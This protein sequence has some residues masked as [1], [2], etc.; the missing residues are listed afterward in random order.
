MKGENAIEDLK[1][2]GYILQ[3]DGVHFTVRLRLPG[4]EITAAQLRALADVADEYGRGE[5]HITTRQGIQIPWVDFDK[6]KEATVKL[7][8]I[9]APPGSCGPRVR[10]ISSCVGLPRCPRAN[11][12]T[13][14][15]TREID[16]RFF[17]RDLPGKLKIAVTGCPNSCAKPQVND[18]GIMAVVRPRIIPKKCDSCGSCLRACKEAAISMGNHIPRIDYAKC[19]S[20]GDCIKACTLCASVEDRSGYSVFLGGKVGRHPR[21]AF[22]ATSFSDEEEVLSIIEGSIKVFRDRGLRKE[23]FGAFIERIGIY[24]FLRDLHLSFDEVPEIGIAKAQ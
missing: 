5:L 16:N 11:A 14:A 24:E 7:D 12:D 3:R 15:L 21:L 4:G 6:L 18:I 23:R 19:I 9:G 2:S 10:N 13:L 8:R 17:D 20:C 1:K 22:K